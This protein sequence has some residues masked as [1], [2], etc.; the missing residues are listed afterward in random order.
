[1]AQA[2]ATVDFY[3]V[4]SYRAR[5]ARE[6]LR[7]AKSV[8]EALKNQIT[9]AH[10]LLANPVSGSRSEIGECAELGVEVVYR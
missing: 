8:C 4:R 9:C 10:Q 6:C 3:D 1:M 2:R 5:Q 7:T